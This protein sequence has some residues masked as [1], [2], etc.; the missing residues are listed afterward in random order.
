MKHPWSETSQ[1]RGEG[2]IHR[3]ADFV[4]WSDLAGPAEGLSEY[5]APAVCHRVPALLPPSLKGEG[6]DRG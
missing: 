6:L 4:G 1:D 5:V 3:V 2:G